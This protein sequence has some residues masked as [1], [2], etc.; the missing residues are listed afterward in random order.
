MLFGEI[1]SFIKSMPLWFLLNISMVETAVV[2]R[3]FVDD[4]ISEK[5]IRP[6]KD[7]I[8]EQLLKW[9]VLNH[10]Q[11]LSI[12]PLEINFIEIL[13]SSALAMEL[14]QSCTKPLIYQWNTKINIS[15]EENAFANVACKTFHYFVKASMCSLLKW[16]W[17]DNFDDESRHCNLDKFPGFT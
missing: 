14:L 13:T 15:L 12:G 16:I 4:K 1:L 17:G 2:Q 6:W 5:L 3:H 9:W 10:G 7:T 8:S 11:V